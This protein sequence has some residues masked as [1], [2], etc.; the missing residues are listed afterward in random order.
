MDIGR[1]INYQTKASHRPVDDDE[2]DDGA[3]EEKRKS[4]FVHPPVAV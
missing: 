1:N 2:D 3:D 4:V